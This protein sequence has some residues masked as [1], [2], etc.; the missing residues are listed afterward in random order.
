MKTTITRATAIEVSAYLTQYDT[1]EA[2]LHQARV[3]LAAIR[4]YTSRVLSRVID[5]LELVVAHP[6]KLDKNLA[7]IRTIATEAEARKAAS[8]YATY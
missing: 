1:P 7:T 4:P 8:A 2:A 6:A 3:Q 5:A